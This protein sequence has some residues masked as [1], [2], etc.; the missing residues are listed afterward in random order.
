M[1]LRFSIDLDKTTKQAN[2]RVSFDLCN[3]NPDWSNG[4]YQ[5]TGNIGKSIGHSCNFTASQPL[6]RS[7]PMQNI[8]RGLRSP[9]DNYTVY[10][11]YPRI[12][13]SRRSKSPSDS[14]ARSQFLQ[15]PITLI[16][17]TFWPSTGYLIKTFTQFG[18]R[19]GL[20]LN[21]PI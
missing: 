16:C 21:Y 4:H 12:P 5:P 3:L 1:Q 9:I 8:V 7:Q 15:P 18:K 10:P 17:L 14:I 13:K 2:P 6:N 11:H 20:I 19:P